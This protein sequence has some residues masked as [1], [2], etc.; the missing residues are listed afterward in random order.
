MYQVNSRGERPGT[1][2]R[3]PKE[4]WAPWAPPSSSCLR[5]AFPHSSLAG[6]RWGFTEPSLQPEAFLR[7]RVRGR[8]AGTWW[9]KGKQALLSAVL[10]G[11]L[12][13]G[14]A[15]PLWS[16]RGSFEGLPAAPVLWALWP[17]VQGT[18][19]FQSSCSGRGS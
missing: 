11:P 18:G 1:A 6:G 5:R 7:L 12:D 14:L 3:K 10:V 17:R 8:R 16:L 19:F 15:L 4:T 13:R 9:E 2:V